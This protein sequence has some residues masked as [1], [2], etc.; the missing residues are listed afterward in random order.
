MRLHRPLA[1]QPVMNDTKWDELRLGMHGLESLSPRWRTKDVQSGYVSEWDTEWFHHFRAGGYATIEWVELAT[2]D[3]AQ[4]QAVLDV[5]ERI[6]LPGEVTAD[7]F[8]V[9]GFV[10]SGQPVDYL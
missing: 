1:N 3:D 4:R 7:G 2:P 10:E 6:H 5:L 8:K 9:F